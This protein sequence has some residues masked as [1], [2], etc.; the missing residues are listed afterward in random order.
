MKVFGPRATGVNEAIEANGA[1]MDPSED[2]KRLDPR[3]TVHLAT[4]LSSIEML[5]LESLRVHMRPQPTRSSLLH[6]IILDWI[7]SQEKRK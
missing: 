3:R 1:F 6:A 7:E 2:A 4:Y 5:R